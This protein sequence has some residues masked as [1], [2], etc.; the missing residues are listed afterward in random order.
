MNLQLL[1][2][3][4]KLTTT[5]TTRLFSGEYQPISR[6]PVTGYG[7]QPSIFPNQRLFN[8]IFRLDPKATGKVPDLLRRLID[9][10][11]VITK[12]AL[13]DCLKD[14]RKSGRY[15]QCLEVNPTFA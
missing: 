9:S 2:L 5:I 11:K 8:E 10:G 4:T 1:K 15:Q 14:L 12:S 6:R 7:T 13:I 3:R